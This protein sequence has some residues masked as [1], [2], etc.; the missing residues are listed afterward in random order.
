MRRLLRMFGGYLAAALGFALV[1][2]FCGWLCRPDLTAEARVRRSVEEIE[3]AAALRRV[4]I[5]PGDPP[6]L[7]REVD[8]SNSGDAPW[9][10]KAQAPILAELVEEGELPPLHE[11][12][13]AEP[14]VL[15]GSEGV[16]RYGG[17]WER[18][19]PQGRNWE[20]ACVLSYPGLV[21]FSPQGLPLVPHVAKSWSVSP[22][23][24]EFVFH[25][26]RG[27]K[28]SDGHPFT[29]DDLLFWWKYEC[30]D[31]SFASSPP[32]ILTTRGKP[33]RVE[34]LG[35]YAVR[36]SFH[37]PNGLFLLRLAT[38]E[39][40]SSMVN[41]PAHYL[42]QYHPTIGDKALIEK[43]MRER[44][45]NDPMLLY[46]HIKDFSNPEHP[47][48]WPWVYRTHRTSGALTYVRNPYYFAVDTQGNQLPYLDRVRINVRSLE[49][50]DQSLA[51]GGASVQRCRTP[52]LYSHLMSQREQYGFQVYHWYPGD[53]S[54]YVIS[55][56]LNRRVAQDDPK[57]AQKHALLN[58]KRF[59]QALSLAIDREEIIKA[60]F[61]A[62][63]EP[64]QAAPGPKSLFYHPRLLKSF[65]AYDPE[66]A[67]RLLDS[68]GLDKRDYEGY[69]TFP[70]G[71]RM[72]F[73]LTH[74]GAASN[75]GPGHFVIE[76]WAEVGVRCILRIRSH[77]LFYTEK[78]A[79]KPD[80]SI[81]GSSS[82]FLPLMDP[83][84]FLP[85]NYESNFALGYARWYRAGGMYGAPE[86][87]E[88]HG[89]TSLT[90]DH[91]L[92]AALQA[93]ERATEE[94][95]PARQRDAFRE[96]LDIAADN[97][98]T[99]SISTPP[100]A[101]MIVKDGF[102]NVP[103]DA[104]FTWSFLTP[105][106]CAPEAF[107]WESP[108]DSPGAIAQIKEEIRR[109]TPAPDAV[110]ATD[111]ARADGGLPLAR[112]IRFLAMGI[113]V[114]V[115]LLVAVKHP[116]VCRRL[117]IMIPTLLIIS[118]VTF[119]VIQLPPGDYLTTMI[120]KLQAAGREADLQTIESIKEMFHIDKP[121]VVRYAHWLGLKWFMS[122]DS[123]DMGL[124]Q[125]Y[126]GRSMETQASVNQIV[127][128]RIL[129]T[130][131]ISLG[132]IL[133]SWFVAIPIGIYSAVRQ[134]T[135]ADYALT[136][137]GFVGMSIPPFLLALILMFASQRWFGVA[138]SGLFSSQYAAQPEWTWGKVLDLMQHIWVPVVVL[139]LGGTAWMIRVMRANLLDELRKP[140]V[141]TARA[142]GMRPFRLLLKYPVRIALNP[143]I[144]GIGGLFPQLLSGGAIVAVVLSL[145]TVGPLLLSALM[146]EDM[147][148]AG[149]M[150]MVLSLLSVFGTL[151]SDLLL[152]WLDPRIRLEG[153]STR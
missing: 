54:N 6:V 8:Y 67:N 18:L 38:W 16:G 138:A 91:P 152:I 19:A 146:S 56:N 134:Y 100:P 130:V 17:T 25:L 78:E 121:M 28:W 77:S 26:R 20:I 3:A 116:Y 5:T 48:L 59:R 33:G 39:G 46:R 137:L 43:T 81:W 14:L 58:D 136:L 133:F 31:K 53:R 89:C 131:L 52:S 87:G 4:E 34:K 153:E 151:V 71:S 105:G 103:R 83:R 141:V 85:V 99:I 10:P 123:K 57:S 118:A 27:M 109:A 15:E 51:E 113:F 122:F 42:S 84:V 61:E 12:V 88:E 149:S 69:R 9:H 29:A 119:T 112:F 108:M 2:W 145:P 49:M 144:S 150:L 47:R 128:D 127:G 107:Y 1:V 139:G 90:K 62:M 104:V 125:G 36:F 13:P 140:Y 135:F 40:F 101:L 114:L 82:E 66:R 72:T 93:Y 132:T 41:A 22:D 92:Y 55:P 60:D 117:L 74:P 110:P 106:N 68:I 50:L 98:W 111:A 143:F 80:F 30:L 94:I 115:L 120:M 126:M 96:V 70:D 45:F 21:R 102:R 76:D 11:R 23:R 124:L 148:L 147:Y 7:Y 95:D 97:A 142:K 63:S 64:A 79:L 24:R 37:R 73:F 32:A 86:A 65:T 44:R 75:P 35:P 129:L